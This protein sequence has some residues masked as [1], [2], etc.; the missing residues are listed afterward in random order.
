V[1]S[2]AECAEESVLAYLDRERGGSEHVRMDDIRNV[3]LEELR[4]LR[5]EL[6]ALRADLDTI[7]VDLRGVKA[8]ITRHVQDSLDGAIGR[9]VNHEETVVVLTD[10]IEL[11]TKCLLEF[12]FGEVHADTDGVRRIVGTDD[13]GNQWCIHLKPRMAVARPRPDIED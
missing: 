11:D 5:E 2:Q 8:R 7:K 3:M 6:H 1:R 9:S 13:D 12:G 4:A 10:D